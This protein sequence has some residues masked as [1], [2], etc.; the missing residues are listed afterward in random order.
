MIE[1]DDPKFE[2][3]RP[4]V[5]GSRCNRWAS[6]TCEAE[7]ATAAAE[8]RDARVG[9]DGLPGPDP[10]GAD[11]SGAGDQIGQAAMDTFPDMDYH[12]GFKPQTSAP[13]SLFA[14]RRANRP[15]VIGTVP[16]GSLNADDR[17]YRSTPMRTRA[18]PRQ[19]E[20]RRHSSGRTST[21]KTRPRGC[22]RIRTARGRRRASARLGHRRSRCR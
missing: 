15:P 18:A 4:A 3:A 17:L 9:V 8:V 14:D 10:S 13:T 5:A 22:R 16:R 19:W 11:R 20:R 12:V 21:M 7:T 1:A 6:R 2:T